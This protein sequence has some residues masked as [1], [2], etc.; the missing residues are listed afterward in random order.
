M[1]SS[2]SISFQPPNHPS[3]VNM[4]PHP[5]M[6]HPCPT[7]FNPSYWWPQ[8]H[9]ENTTFPPHFQ[10]PPDTYGYSKPPNMF[11]NYPPP[12]QFGANQ[13]STISQAPMYGYNQPSQPRPSCIK[14]KIQPIP[15]PQYHASQQQNPELQGGEAHIGNERPGTS[16]TKKTD[17]TPTKGKAEKYKPKKIFVSTN[18]RGLQAWSEVKQDTMVVFEI[19]GIL[20]SQVTSEGVKYCKSFLIKDGQG[21]VI[22]CEFYETDRQLCRTCRGKMYR[23]V[24]DF[25]VRRGIFHAVCVREADEKDVRLYRKLVAVANATLKN[26][27]EN[28]NAKN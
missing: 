27:K 20:N 8:T 22:N 5:G 13:Y 7:I 14:N 25:N 18:A 9:G 19:I 23:C 3:N 1:G 17:A 10:M 28:Y 15:K 4:Y 12:Q 24:G 2:G 26:F 11:Q 6:R 21:H 16:A